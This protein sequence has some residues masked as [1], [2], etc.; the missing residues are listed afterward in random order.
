MPPILTQILNED[1]KTGTIDH[2][3]KLDKAVLPKNGSE[4]MAGNLDMNL[5]QVVNMIFESGTSFPLTPA[6]GQVFYRTDQFRLYVWDGAWTLQGGGWVD[7]GTLVSLITAGDRVRIGATDT[8]EKLSVSGSIALGTGGKYRVYLGGTYLDALG[9]DGNKLRIGESGLGYDT[10]VVGVANHSPAGVLTVG[11]S[12]LAVG[13]A[14]ATLY[15]RVY[16]DSSAN[17]LKIKALDSAFGSDRSII[18]SAVVSGIEKEVAR[19]LSGKLGIGTATPA[20]PLD[21]VGD[22][23]SSTGYRVAGTPLAVTNLS[24]SASIIRTTG[25]VAFGANQSM[26]GFRLTSVGSPTSG[27]DA[28]NRTFVENLVS[29][30]FWLE[31]VDARNLVG[32]NTVANLDLLT[33]TAGDAYVATDAGTLTRGSVVVS[34]GDLV[35]DNGT[36]W[37]KLVTNVGTYPPAGVRAILAKTTPLIAPYTD[38][39][40]DNKIAV[41]SGSSL[42]AALTPPVDGNSV[43]IQDPGS[44]GYY[45]NAAYVFEGSGPT[46]SWVQWTGAGGVNAGAGLDKVGNTL[47]V[48]VGDGIQVDT[49]SLTVLLDGVSLAKSVSGLKV[50][51]SGVTSTEL[52]TLRPYPQAVPDNTVRVRPGTYIKVT[53][54]GKVVLAAETTSPVFS[55]VTTGGRTRFDLLCALDNG[56]LAVTA[57][58]EGT[59]GTIPVYPSDRQVIAEIRVNETGTAV[60]DASDVTD[61]RG[62]LNLGVATGAA[63]HVIQSEG[64]SQTQHLNLNFIGD[65]VA[66]SEDV[67]NNATKVTVISTDLYREVYEVGTPSGNYTGSLSLFN[68]IASY[69]QNGKQLDVFVNGALQQVGAPNDYIETSTTAATFNY[70]LVAGD[71]VQF[72]W[73]RAAISN[74]TPSAGV[75]NRE[76]FI[77]AGPTFT[78]STP[79]VMGGKNLKVYVDGWLRRPGLDYSEVTPVSISF[80]TTLWPGPMPAASKI[81]CVWTTDVQNLVSFVPATEV[82]EDFPASGA[83]TYNLANAFVQGGSNLKSF[84]DGVLMRL[85]IDYVE[86]TNQRVDFQAGSIPAIGQSVAFSWIR[87]TG[88]LGTTNERRDEFV[89]T[90][91]QKVFPLSFTY[92]LGGESLLVFEDGSLK[93]YGVDYTEISSSQISFVTGRTVGAR[94]TCMAR[95]RAAAG[96]ADTVDG[97]HGTEILDM[98]ALAGM[99]GE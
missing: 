8:S 36:I 67:G 34:Q 51:P 70:N 42:T 78:L 61:V 62:F 97:L 50:A 85:G 59:P 19:L 11:G 29:G 73:T 76:E 96:D 6:I 46:G 72:I 84:V 79:Y 94:I 27:T 10:V 93:K 2:N 33:P 98:A 55:P 88:Y 38:A 56:T 1:I 63:G 9:V 45:D 21:V 20:Y 28:A 40:D 95:L 65:G 60:I 90:S 12:G 18:F 92:P 23:N 4:P 5:Y 22:I 25:S 3:T 16:D 31:P 14:S 99:W 47:F 77:G 68:L 15:S 74:I 26:G 32:N 24:D 35:E 75:E 39:T 66:V 87:S 71:V 49:N 54:A 82:R 91:G 13:S 53:G 37:V 7:E 44:I 86:T 64:V 43:L 83:A 57:G 69:V 41:F 80:I 52:G 58:V 89:A 30:F 48:G 81:A 17:A